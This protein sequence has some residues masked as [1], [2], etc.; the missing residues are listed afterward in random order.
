MKTMTWSMKT[1]LSGIALSALFFLPGKVAYTQLGIPEDVE[2]V[3]PRPAEPPK[4]PEAAPSSQ[5]EATSAPTQKKSPLDVGGPKDNQGRT[6][7]GTGQPTNA[8]SLPRLSLNGFG[9]VRIGMTLAEV[10]AAG[11]PL[12]TGV[13]ESVFCSYV[14]PTGMPEGIAFMVRNGQ[15]A[16][17]DI[18]TSAYASMS[19]ARVGQT[20]EEVLRL[21]AGRLEISVHKYDPDGAYLTYI[22]KDQADQQYRM[23]FETD[24]KRITRFRAGRLPEVG[25]VEGCA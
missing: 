21:Y 11:V 19:G 7:G 22:P 12:D 23:I 24:G 17:I 5:S 14:K 4:P 6:I 3:R 18:T 2:I 8:E 9:P 1:F 25:W 15:I 10:Q 13:S 20:Q 16:R